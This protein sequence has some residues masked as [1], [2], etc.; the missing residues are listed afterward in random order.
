MYGHTPGHALSPCGPQEQY[1]TDQRCTALNDGHGINLF[2]RASGMSQRN[3]LWI[4][5]GSSDI[6]RYST[7]SPSDRRV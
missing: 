4:W 3:F 5:T 7:T 2:A 6:M 1:R